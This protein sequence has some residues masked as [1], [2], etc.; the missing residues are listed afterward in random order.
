MKVF[1]RSI[2][3]YLSLAAGLVIMVTC[4]TGA[5]LVF[6]EEL[7][8]AFNHD[9]YYVKPA[10][11][12]LPVSTLIANLEAKQPGAKVSGI[13]LYG[14]PER[15]VELTFTPGKKGE[16]RKK[17]GGAATGEKAGDAVATPLKGDTG[18][19]NAQNG[20]A[21]VAALQAKGKKAEK[22]GQEKTAGDKGGKAPA[23]KGGGKKAFM[24]PYT[25][26]LIEVYVYQDT[27]FYTMFA[28]HRWMLG[29]AVG[30]VIVGVSTL[31]FLFILLTGIILWWPK[32]K[33]ILIQRVKVKWTA[34]W[35][36]LNHD[37]HIVLG[38]YTAIF[39]FIF[40]FTGLAW[41][42]EWFNNGIYKVTGS[43]PKGT[44]PPSSQY[45]ENTPRISFD[46][47][48]QLAAT[49]APGAYYYNLSAPK[50]SAAA[51]VVNLLPADAAHESATTN[52]F[53]DQYA[54]KVLKVQPFSERNLGQRVRSSFKPIHVSSIYGIPSKIIGFIVCLLGVTFPV[55][56]IIMWIQRL[57]K[58]AKARKNREKR[59]PVEMAA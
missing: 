27:F 39:L 13:R 30:K 51:F 38:F 53:I 5:V 20:D 59:E 33:N 50:D 49:A 29:G 4:F 12:K 24:N 55:T 47:A 2:H 17:D 22:N 37:L 3:L 19:V 15:S 41:S 26:E 32:T 56:G 34:G 10:G 42:F 40:A 45:T 7:N 21:A 8:H 1:F 16:G 18:A 14:D 9:R 46:S 31:V 23:G 36:R 28:L 54:A 58:K 48:Y 52:V 6:E 44:P 57:K 11:E 25:G 35:K 43:D